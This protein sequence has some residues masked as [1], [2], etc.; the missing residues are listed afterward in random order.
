[1]ATSWQRTLTTRVL[2]VALDPH[3]EP[4]NSG[5]FVASHV[6]PGR[7]DCFLSALTLAQESGPPIIVGEVIR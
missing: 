4:A 7:A 5:R 3:R 6:I 2:H 1:M